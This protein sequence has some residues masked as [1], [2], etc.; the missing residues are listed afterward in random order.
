MDNL[1]KGIWPLSGFEPPGHSVRNL[2]ALKSIVAVEPAN[3]LVDL[4]DITFS[5]SFI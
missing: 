4:C 1:E 3:D 2:M 5:L